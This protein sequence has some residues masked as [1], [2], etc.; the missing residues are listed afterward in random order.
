MPRALQMDR[1]SARGHALAGQVLAGTHHACGPRLP[2]PLTVALH[3]YTS[4]AAHGPSTCLLGHSG[5][6]TVELLSRCLVPSLPPFTFRGTLAGLEQ[7]GQG[8]GGSI[9]LWCRQP[10]GYS[11]P[12]VGLILS[13]SPSQHRSKLDP[14]QTTCIVCWL[15]TTVGS[16][17][18]KP[19]DDDRVALLSVDSDPSKHPG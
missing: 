6:A 15:S 8:G 1:A 2:L 4:N 17:K 10:P 5:P 16:P 13:D 18:T 11:L 14:A 12:C 7:S 9:P 19:G 3:G